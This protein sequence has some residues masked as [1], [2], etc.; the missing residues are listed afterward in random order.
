MTNQQ[1]EKI[2]NLQKYLDKCQQLLG[3]PTPE[4]HKHRPESYKEFIQ[5]EVTKTKTALEKLKA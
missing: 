2:A 5:R 4:K 1:K 3:D